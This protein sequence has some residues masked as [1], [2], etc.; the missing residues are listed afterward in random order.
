MFINAK[1]L[2]FYIV[3]IKSFLLTL[4]ADS[5]KNTQPHFNPIDAIN[6]NP[7]LVTT[8]LDALKIGANNYR[9]YYQ[10]HKVDD[11]NDILAIQLQNLKDNLNST[12][13]L[14]KWWELLTSSPSSLDLDTLSA[15]N[16][17]PIHSQPP[18]THKNSY[19]STQP[20]F[21]QSEQRSVVST[22]PV[23][24]LGLLATFCMVVIFL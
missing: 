12:E 19:L 13:K 14:I 6:S 2:L 20:P 5:T 4:N 10:T 18:L 21:L 8:F 11:T 24:G 16:T 17:N 7:D 23:V 3:F 9:A 15:C 22:T 1:R